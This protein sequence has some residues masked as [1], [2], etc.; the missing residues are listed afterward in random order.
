MAYL[1][2]QSPLQ[3]KDGDYFYPLTTVDQVVMEDGSRLNSVFK[4][5]VKTNATLLVSN[6]TDE[7]P[8]TQTIILDDNIDTELNIDVNI[9]Y[10]GVKE[11]DDTLNNAAGCLTYIKKDGNN[12][13]FYCL[14]KKP[15]ID[16][17][18][19]IE[20]TC[21]NSIASVEEGIKLNFRVVGGTTQPSNPMENTIWIN[22]GTEITSWEFS[23]TKPTGLS[24]MVWIGTDDDSTISLNGLKQNGIQ[25]YLKSAN[26]YINNNW[27][28]VEAYI[29]TSD[30]WKQ[31]A[32]I[33]LYLYKNGDRNIPVTG[34]FYYGSTVVSDGTA[35]DGTKYLDFPSPG[36]DG[37]RDYIM[38]NKI[39][40]TPFT[41]L[42]EK[43]KHSRPEGPADTIQILGADNSVVASVDAA[44]KPSTEMQTLTIDLST[45]NAT[46]SIRFH[47][48]G[49]GYDNWDL[50]E[51]YLE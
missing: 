11:T 5:T 40:L 15:E 24:G 26:Q 36:T 39:D 12:I 8:Y 43:S 22:T 46:Y 32:Y 6:W 41:R 33:I 35:S 18:I 25:I 10:S 29:Y 45:L 20:G 16:I 2:P 44:A 1:K 23:K 17:P 47:D 51:L 31:F 27:T 38:K 13:I 9:T 37:T 4:H 19:E 21:T 28:P 7:A 14:K 48:Y 3:H 50:Y 42:V 34:D 49:N 30:E